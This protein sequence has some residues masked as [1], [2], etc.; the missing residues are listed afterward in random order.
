[1]VTV[2]T[3]DS[4]ASPTNGTIFVSKEGIWDLAKSPI[5][6]EKILPLLD[7]YPNQADA[8]FLKDGLKFGFK[9]H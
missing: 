2:Q 3:S 8:F 6:V 9:L 5:N 1:M 7:N 4:Q